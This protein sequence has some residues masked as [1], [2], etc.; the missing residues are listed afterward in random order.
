MSENKQMKPVPTYQ[1]PQ[2]PAP[3]PKKKKKK[4]PI[5]LAVILAIA[6]I[7]GIGSSMNGGSEVPVASESS[8]LSELESENSLVSVV[9]DTSSLSLIHI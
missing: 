9:T 1:P 2:G 5:V 4:W 3:S 8:A 6:V 7:G